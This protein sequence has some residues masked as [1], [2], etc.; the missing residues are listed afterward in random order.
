MHMSFVDREVLCVDC[1]VMFVFSAGEQEFFRD[2]GFTHE[3]KRCKLC[4]AKR[5]GGKAGHRI[6]TQVTCS[7]CGNNTTVP[8]KPTQGRPVLCAS[9]FSRTKGVAVGATSRS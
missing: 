8:F 7:E 3:P 4:K 2:K 9:C 6:E 5:A 1:G